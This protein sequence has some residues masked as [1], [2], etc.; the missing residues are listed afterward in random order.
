MARILITSGPTRQYLDPVRYLSN[1][2]SGTMGLCLCQSAL[3]L[4]HDV[5]VVSGPVQVQYPSGSKVIPVIT[6]EQMDEVA[7]REFLS[8]DGMIG[9]AAP[10]DYKPELVADRKIKKSGEALT[11]RFVETP[12]IIANLGKLKR[13]DQWSVGFA[14]ETDDGRSKAIAKLKKKNCDLV[15]LNGVTAIDSKD[16]SIEIIDRSGKTV[17][18]K[19]GPK[20]EV[21]DLILRTIDR[22]L[23]S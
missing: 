22:L 5:V 14:L 19:E 17:A 21:A 12:D 3:R 18:E 7:S 16:N 13:S 2:S 1:A 20:S 9:A 23:I 6:T 11:L 8:C 15:V 4:G 10:C